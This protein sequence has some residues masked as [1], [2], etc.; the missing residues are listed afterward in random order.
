M[1]P[2]RPVHEPAESPAD[3][4]DALLAGVEPLPYPHRMRELALHAR[5]MAGTPE[6]NALLAELSTR[7]HYER[8]TAL[9]LAMA[10]REMGHITAVLRGP[11]MELR[12]AALR[13]VRTL[14][15]PDEA[16][17]AVLDDA[18]AVLR[19]AFY[20]TLL[21]AGRRELADRLLPLVRERWGDREAAKLLPACGEATV[22]EALPALA[23]AVAAWRALGRR[24]P[25]AVLDCADQ[26]LAGAKWPLLWWRRRG[27]GV[28]A[29]APREPGRVL[30]LIEDHDLAFLAPRL[31]PVT[32]AAMLKADRSRAGRLLLR[33]TRRRFPGLMPLR[34]A[35][36]RSCSVEEILAAMPT[37]SSGLGSF[38]EA[39]PPG[40]REAIFDAVRERGGGAL[41]R[42]RALP[43]L[44]LL[45]PERAAAEARRMLDWQ[46]SAWHSSR[47]GADDPEL[48]LKLQAFL[49]YEEAAGPL[50]EAAFAGDPR[51]RGLARTLLLESAART[52]DRGVLAE[53]VDRLV[54]RSVNEQDPVRG[55]LLA[56]LA[57]LRPALFGDAFAEPLDRL[58]AATVE[59]RDSSPGTRRALRALAARVL[60]HAEGP[61]LT[62]WALNVYV[63]LVARHGADGLAAEPE[64]DQHARRRPARVA[65]EHRLD[66][67][68]R[69]GREREL[70]DLLSPHLRAA[71]DR[72]DFDLAVALARSL[73]RRAYGL[74]SLQDDLYSAALHAPAPLAREAAD[75]WLGRRDLRE[76]RAVRLLRADPA[77]IARER[78]WR[79]VAGRRTDL[80]VAA[81]DG[82]PP[83]DWA[84]EIDT[85]AAGR[86]TPAQRGH[87]RAFLGATVA[88]ERLPVASRLT[89]VA[90]L[91]RVPGSLAGLAG[92]AGGEE[93]V[94]AEGAL[95][96][97]ARAD[98][99]YRALRILLAHGRGPSSRVAV[100]AMATCCGRVPPS[101]LGPL[102]EEALT[103]PDGKVTVRK[104]AARL[105][106][107]ERLP[108]ASGILLRAWA[109]PGLHKDV[110]VAVAV[111]LRH[112]PAVPGA[113]E[114]LDEA[115]GPYA[116]EVMLRTLFQAQPWDYAPAH[117]PR[118][119]AL[120]RRLLGAAEGPGVRFRAARAFSAWGPWYE[121]GFAEILTAVGD[122]GDPAGRR[123]LPVFLSLLRA[124]TG[125]QEIAGVL[126][127]LLAAEMSTEA[128]SRVVAIVHV[129][130]E[131][132]TDQDVSRRAVERL[133]RHPLY[134]AEALDLSIACLPGLKEGEAVPAGFREDLTGALLAF[135]ARLRGEPVLAAQLC[136]R[137][138]R[139]LASSRVGRPIPPQDLLPAVRSLRDEED[140]AAELIALTL[141]GAAG[142]PA[143]W[144]GEWRTVL[145]GMRRSRYREIQRRAWE[146]VVE[147]PPYS[148]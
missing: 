64:P 81:M 82:E 137:L 55:S 114:A 143:G 148:P 86:W 121:G 87:V 127:R 20:R 96:A 97:L 21:H 107:R 6:L 68:L 45:P 83:Q 1:S 73:G 5:R 62:A 117:R 147:E 48:P 105:L 76:E 24:H 136:D 8:R 31:S 93:N 49:P 109:D 26:E 128:R 37:G 25:G 110:R 57:G 98:E 84:P 23:H 33:S 42:L 102:L 146:I 144:S 131:G 59:A 36:L 27:A 130:H 67:V 15:V 120:V 41:T 14:P 12:R 104:Q 138:A 122:P 65:D 17:A 132:R 11:D 119:A 106:E 88:D 111:A 52:G 10:A 92:W 3:A 116:G 70:L 56:A 50:G 4:A 47:S 103:G 69:R 46:K 74:A 60:R 35:Y 22:R 19:R 58:A 43:V 51:R 16:A 125:H 126:D 142:P 72:G 100:A 129:L 89:A 61:A 38:L 78:V 77:A 124:G 30:A 108:G 134:L 9:H 29:A 79:V 75:L 118:Y 113:L 139:R 2:T 28:E 123:D 91:G 95:D 90:S 44:P 135:A 141:A 140:L 53:S 101:R 63:R 99:P 80:L 66:R 34:T 71:R 13:A 7:D 115:A 18:P 40:R 85:G 94:L 39:Q 54:A 112:L 32:F 145:D 133:A